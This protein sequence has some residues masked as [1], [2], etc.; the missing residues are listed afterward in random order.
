MEI[1]A[2]QVTIQEIPKGDR[3]IRITVDKM[4]NLIRSGSIDQDVRLQ[5][6][7]ISL[8]VESEPQRPRWSWITSYIDHVFKFAKSYTFA[9]DSE[10]VA[11][12]FP[13]LDDPGKV[14]LLRSANYIIGNKSARLDCDDYSILIGSL[15]GAAKVPVRLVVIAAKPL[16]P[17]KYSHV[18]PE[19]RV[20]GQW[21]AMDALLDRPG[22]YHPDWS[23]RMF[24]NV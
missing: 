24:I 12:T 18:F 17:R 15:M 4:V 3:G 1:V 22:D 14:E 11:D 7:I 13:E 23:R 2:H 9:K 19:V 5:R 6:D 16:E 8:A 21:I 20:H 10:V